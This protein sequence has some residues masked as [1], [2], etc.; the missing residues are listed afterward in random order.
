[1]AGSGALELWGMAR[2]VRSEEDLVLAFVFES[3]GTAAVRVATG[4][5]LELLDVPTGTQAVATTGISRTSGHLAR[6]A[7][8]YS[9]VIRN[10]PRARH[11]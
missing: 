11:P 3:E 1:M 10:I 5:E 7:P 2:D 8:V 9:A 4:R 6:Q